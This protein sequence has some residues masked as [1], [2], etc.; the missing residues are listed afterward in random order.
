MEYQYG[1]GD[2]RLFVSKV[3][4]LARTKLKGPSPGLARPSQMYIS[5]K[6]FRL[7]VE[8]GR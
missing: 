7:Q 5:G 8:M 6:F 1:E 3:T 2:E 4:E